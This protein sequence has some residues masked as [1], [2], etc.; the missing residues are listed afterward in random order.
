MRKKE[1][2]KIKGFSIFFLLYKYNQEMAYRKKT[3]KRTMKKGGKRHGTR[4]HRK[5]ARK[6]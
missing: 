6:H 1:N 5:T 4:K 3:S 2:L